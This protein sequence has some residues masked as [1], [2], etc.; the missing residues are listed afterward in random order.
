MSDFKP[1][2]SPRVR[3]CVYF[4]GLIWGAI[5][6]LITAIAAVWWPDEAVRIL[7]TVG[8]VSSAVAFLAGGLGVM[9]RPPI[10]GG[11]DA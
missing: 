6:T 5:A 1:E 3:T 8:G 10:H 11:V 7:A 2:V 9:Y 4:A